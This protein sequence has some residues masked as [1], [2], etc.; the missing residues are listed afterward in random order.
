MNNSSLSSS[1]PSSSSSSSSS[2]STSYT[3]YRT[4]CLSTVYPRS[5][6]EALRVLIE[7]LVTLMENLMVSIKS[8]LLVVQWNLT[9]HL[10]IHISFLLNGSRVRFVKFFWYSNNARYIHLTHFLGI[11]GC[12]I[13]LSWEA[14]SPP[15]S[16]A[17]G[18][19]FGCPYRS[20]VVAVPHF[21]GFARCKGWECDVNNKVN[22]VKQS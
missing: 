1:S 15:N 8:C 20:W 7:V 13:F 14:S 4:S 9:T 17:A 12:F 19:F 11:N 6:C 10:S 3:D 21:L 2:S 5:R 18:L 16:A 22:I